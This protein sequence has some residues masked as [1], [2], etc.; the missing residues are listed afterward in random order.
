M[1]DPNE[2]TITCNICYCEHNVSKSYSLSWGHPFGITCLRQ[3]LQVAIRDGKVIDN[4]WAQY[5]WDVK[6]QDADI[7]KVITNPELIQK[8]E[9]FK[10]NIEVN[11]DKSKQWW[12]VANWGL[13]VK[14]S[15]WKPKAQWAN[16]HQFCFI[17]QQKW[18]NGNWK[19]NFDEQF[20]DWTSAHKVA[21]CP[22]CN[23]RIEKNEGWNHMTCFCGYQW[24]W[25]WKDK[26]SQYH[27]KRWNV[28]GWANMQF[29]VGWSK[30]KIIAFY[31]FM[32][33]V[34]FP[35]LLLF[36]P[37]IYMIKGCLYPNGG[38]DNWIAPIWLIPKLWMSGKY[39]LE[40]R[41]LIYLCI[42][43]IYLIKSN[44]KIII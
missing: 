25:L 2:D 29:T 20:M 39:Y 33:L 10:E 9:K 30:W 38:Y 13:W 27:Y 36:C 1:L 6:F 4:K 41:K 22:K 37:L 7:R 26:Y 32:I 18:H 28:F 24:C 44:K 19:D 5:D 42:W 11:L 8:Y 3:M 17:W 31:I 14:G 34:L 23:V 16:G 21:K 35:L 43:Y 12:P 15:Q 40:K